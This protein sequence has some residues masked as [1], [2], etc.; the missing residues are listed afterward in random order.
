MQC[1]HAA[2][3]RL[4]AVIVL[5]IA[6]PA[7][8]Q[9]LP[10]GARPE[11]H[12]TDPQAVELAEA[13]ARGDLKG[14]DKLIAA[15]ADVNARGKRD[16]TP[17]IFAVDL[18]RF[19]SAYRLLAS[20]ADYRARDR[21]GRDLPW[22]FVTGTSINPRTDPGRWLAKTLDWLVDRGVNF[23]EAE[24][25]LSHRPA[26][27]I[28]LERWRE[29]RAVQSLRWSALE[30]KNARDY[31][32]RGASRLAKGNDDGALADFS[33]AIKLQPDN[34]AGYKFRGDVWSDKR[35]M[36]DDTAEP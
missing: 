4:A 36:T 32:L 35:L 23:R 8:A 2:F 3:R 9:Q 25:K 15:G 17:L 10:T 21:Q 30:P 26:Q 34:A 12:W 33:E 18:N 24:K 16:V 7:A 29:V 31:R 22:L 20:G 13:I 6:G 5:G 28:T 19:D 1:R 27:S 14:I 11:I